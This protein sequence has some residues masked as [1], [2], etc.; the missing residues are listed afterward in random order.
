M[1]NDIGEILGNLIKLLV[2]SFV[3]KYFYTEKSALRG[4][5]LCLFKN[6]N[7]KKNIVHLFKMVLKKGSIMKTVL[8]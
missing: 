8:F 5:I 1:K 7:K 2:P 4:K 3:E 6:K